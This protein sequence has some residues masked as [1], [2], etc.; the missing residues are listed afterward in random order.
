MFKATERDFSR[1]A[2]QYRI[3][4]YFRPSR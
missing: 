2:C 4:R 1:P 3:R